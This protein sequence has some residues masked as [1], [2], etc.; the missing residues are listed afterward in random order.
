MKKNVSKK[1]KLKLSMNNIKFN[2]VG[3][4]GYSG[5]TK[6]Q[7]SYI[8]QVLWSS[9][10]FLTITG[11]PTVQLTSDSNYPELASNPER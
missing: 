6:I 8:T 9:A 4:G 1:R 11:C 3:K 7:K 5:I 2:E 10:N